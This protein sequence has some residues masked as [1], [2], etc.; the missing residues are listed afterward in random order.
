MSIQD[1]QHLQDLPGI[2]SF[3]RGNKAKAQHIKRLILMKPSCSSPDWTRQV[4]KSCLISSEFSWYAK[5]VYLNPELRFDFFNW[6]GKKAFQ[7]LG[8]KGLLLSCRIVPC[9]L[10]QVCYRWPGV[11]YVFCA[12]VSQFVKPSFSPEDVWKL[13]AAHTAQ[14]MLV[15]GHTR[16]VT[17][18]TRGCHSVGCE[19]WA[20]TSF[21][22]WS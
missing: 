19:L 20:P 17:G 3:P 22:L 6:P 21:A 4:H 1:Q 11:N 2:Q 13:T 15:G 14:Q 12:F 10:F 5:R 9:M 8:R 16:E 18:T 7:A